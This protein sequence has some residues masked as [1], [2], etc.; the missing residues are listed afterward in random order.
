MA[1]NKQQSPHLRMRVE[2]SGN[3]PAIILIQTASKL[4]ICTDS[5]KPRINLNALN[6]LLCSTFGPVH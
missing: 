1:D 4:I 3:L 5:H 2:S 6:N